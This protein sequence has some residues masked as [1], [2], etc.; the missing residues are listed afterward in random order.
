MGLPVTDAVR[1]LFAESEAA[2][3]GELDY[4]AIFAQLAG[5]V[6]HAS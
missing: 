6:S 3:K 5:T 4:S 1:P 2:G